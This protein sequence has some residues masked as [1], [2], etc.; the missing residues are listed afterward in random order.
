MNELKFKS[1]GDGTCELVLPD[2]FAKEILYV[3]EKN[4]DGEKVISVNTHDNKSIKKIFLPATL[5]SENYL[6]F[7]LHELEEVVVAP[8]NPYFSSFEGIIF[9]KD[10][11]TLIRCPAK[12]S[13]KFVAPAS[14]RT[15]A[16]FAFDNDNYCLEE[17]IFQEGL[18][19]TEQYSLYR[20]RIVTLPVT[21]TDIDVTTF[22][23][24]PNMLG[25]GD[26][27]SCAEKFIC[28]LFCYQK[29]LTIYTER[30]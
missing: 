25:G 10:M 11:T 24:G 20:A 13:G 29:S 18:Q 3:P 27:D 4:P 15:V 19:R 26:T 6:L 28:S 5:K 22:K 16:E 14:V 30:L 9:S 21:L 2:D 8:E 17:I 1:N 7:R 23:E 12:K